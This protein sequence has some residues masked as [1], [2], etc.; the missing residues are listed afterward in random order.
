MYKRTDTRLTPFQNYQKS[1]MCIILY[2]DH[3]KMA[4]ESL[5]IWPLNFPLFA[6]IKQIGNILPLS[7]Q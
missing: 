6:N 7:V 2:D 4:R 5:L 3:V 1:M